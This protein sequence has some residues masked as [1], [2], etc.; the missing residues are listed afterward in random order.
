MACMKLQ[1]LFLLPWRVWSLTLQNPGDDHI[2]SD[3]INQLWAG[4]DIFD[5]QIVADAMRS[6]SH[7]HI[8]NTAMLPKVQILGMFDSGTNLLGALLTKNLGAEVFHQMCPGSDKE[9]YHC[10]FWKH[11]PPQDVHPNGLHLIAVV[12]SPLA[13]MSGWIK[14]PYD[15]SKCV[16]YINWL[17]DESSICSLYHTEMDATRTFNGPTGVWN[18]FVQGYA[19]L[20]AQGATIKI[21]EY[22]NIVLNTESVIRDIGAFVG[23]PVG[24]F[25]QISEPAKTHG[26]PVGRELALQH[27]RNRTYLDNFPWEDARVVKKVCKNLNPSIM[28]HHSFKLSSSEVRLYQSDCE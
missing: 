20:A 11:T 14:A 5:R 23:V 16:S 12:R 15:L 21:V 22:E 8:N 18:A 13:H 9:G 19:N 27:I 17:S 26:L 7:A 6:H 25:Q 10:H 24:H 2:G 4:M 3:S 28:E 1:A